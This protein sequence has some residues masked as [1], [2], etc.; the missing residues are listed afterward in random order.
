MIIRALRE[1]TGVS[2]PQ[3]W[4]NI[5]SGAKIAKEAWEE[6]AKGR[7]PLELSPDDVRRFYRT[8]DAYLWDLAMWHMGPK[9]EHDRVTA[10]KWS[11][12][13]VKTVLD[14]GCGTGFNAVAFARCGL[15]VEAVDLPGRT[16]EFCRFRVKQLGLGSLI[17]IREHDERWRKDAG[18]RKWDT[19]Y[20]SDVLEHYPTYEAAYAEAKWLRERAV[21]GC[22]MAV[23]FGTGGGVHPMHLPESPEWEARIKALVEGTP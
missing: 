17:S 2:E 1:F 16:L 4:E 8:T 7:G 20:C 6:F 10:E 14:F 9:R 23:S 13:G 15:R 11:K 21:K 12:A 19:V 18:R 5:M 22:Y 3:V